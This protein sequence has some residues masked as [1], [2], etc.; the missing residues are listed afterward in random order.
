MGE[1]SPLLLTDS[2][3]VHTHRVMSE[4]GAG[5]EF[6]RMQQNSEQKKNTRLRFIYIS[7]RLLAKAAGGLQ[8]RAVPCGPAAA[9]ATRCVALPKSLRLVVTQLRACCRALSPLLCYL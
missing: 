5:A 2:P 4:L 8:M 9:A 3:L 7:R 1:L 6:S